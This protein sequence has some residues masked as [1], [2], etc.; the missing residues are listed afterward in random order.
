MTPNKW[1]E[2]HALQ[3]PKTCKF[4]Q[5][6]SVI[7]HL[8][9]WQTWTRVVLGVGGDAGKVPS[10]REGTA[11]GDH[12]SLQ[13]TYSCQGIRSHSPLGTPLASL[14]LG[15]EKPLS[16][17]TQEHS[18]L[19]QAYDLFQGQDCS[20][21]PQLL[22][23]LSVPVQLILDVSESPARRHVALQP[24]QGPPQLGWVAWLM[25]SVEGSLGTLQVAGGSQ[26]GPRNT[27]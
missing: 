4:T 15:P 27:P 19:A 17:R 23:C 24:G 18:A 14:R 12:L 16:V 10:G 6:G 5:P 20:F 2:A 22:A 1:K 3:K 11:L 25:T 8:P 7:S 13:G 26:S 9:N 21:L